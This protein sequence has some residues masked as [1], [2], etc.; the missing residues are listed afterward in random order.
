MLYESNNIMPGYKK[1]WKILRQGW[2]QWM[3]LTGKQ[4]HDLVG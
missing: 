1:T 3:K 2:T 4:N